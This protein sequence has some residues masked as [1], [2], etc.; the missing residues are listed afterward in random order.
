MMHVK[1]SSVTRIQEHVLAA[2]LAL[3][4]EARAEV[5]EQLLQS[6]ENGD[7]AEIDAEW[8]AEIE[9]RIDDLDSGRMKTIPGEDVFARIFSRT[10]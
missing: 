7:H 4:P 6:L 10:K 1:E 3:P 8:V 2:G 5:A 9:R